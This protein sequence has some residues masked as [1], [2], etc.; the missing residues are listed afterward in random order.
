MLHAQIRV[1]IPQTKLAF[2]MLGLQAKLK[3]KSVEH[4][5]CNLHG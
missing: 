3:E 4:L 2:D 1:G 5:G